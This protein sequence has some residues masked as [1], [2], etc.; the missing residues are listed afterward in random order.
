M[1]MEIDGSF[2]KDILCN[3]SG[4]MG[5]LHFFMLRYVCLRVFIINFFLLLFVNCLCS[6]FLLQVS[7]ERC[8]C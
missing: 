2:D 8:L 6:S 7:F 4:I 5:A 3:G 1:K